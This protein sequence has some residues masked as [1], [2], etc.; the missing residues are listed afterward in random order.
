ME[1]PTVSGSPWVYSGYSSGNVGLFSSCARSCT[2]NC[3]SIA[4]SQV[5][6]RSALFGI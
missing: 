5:A 6:F 4:A 2:S 3:S 1:N